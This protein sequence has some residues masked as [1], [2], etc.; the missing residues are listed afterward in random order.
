MEH[1][2]SISHLSKSFGSSDKRLV[3]FENFNLK[4]AEARVTSIVGPTGCG[5]TTLLNIIAGIEKPDTGKVEFTSGSGFRTGYMLQDS[6]L[7]PWRTLSENAMLGSEIFNKHRVKSSKEL[8]EYFALF[9]LADSKNSYPAVS[10]GGM[11]RRVALIRTL[12]TE[13]SLLLLDEPFVDLDFDIR[14]KIQRRL[15]RYFEKRNTTIVLVTHDIE[16]AVAL[17]DIVIVLSEK[18]TTIKSQIKIELGISRKDPV[19]ARKSPKFRDYFVHIWD[20][21]KY[22]DNND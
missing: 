2:F 11:K 16:D 20:E 8:D 19:E 1:L 17:G 21:L 10:S 15:I 6:L 5:K 12:L 13:P 18:P 14:P 3:L 9:D 7:L 22:L 4:A